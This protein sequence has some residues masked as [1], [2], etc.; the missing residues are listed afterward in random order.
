MCG[1]V[2][3]RVL[4][5][6][7]VVLSGSAAQAGAQVPDEQ[8]GWRGT[9]S[10]DASHESTTPVGSASGSASAVYY[11]DG[12]FA[13]GKTAPPIHPTRREW[14]QS[15]DWRGAYS[16][17]LDG[18][19]GGG[20][21]DRTVTF[22][23]IGSQ[24]A[25]DFAQIVIG[26]ENGLE[27]PPP[28][29]LA[30]VSLGPT[31]MQST[32]TTT[33][34][35]C[36]SPP[37]V[38]TITEPTA[39]CAPLI[40]DVANPVIAPEGTATITLTPT[41][42]DPTGGCSGG[43][44]GGWEAEV[45]WSLSRAPDPPECSDGKDNDI[46]KDGLIDYSGGLVQ[47]QDP[48]CENAQDNSEADTLTVCSDG[49]DNDNDGLIDLDDPGC[50]NA[51]D[52]EE[53]DS[54]CSDGH[55]NDGDDRNNYPDDPGCDSAED[56]T[57]APDPECGDLSDNDDDGQI[58]FPDDPD[59]V[60]ERDESEHC[61]V[62]QS[63]SS[64]DDEDEV[65]DR[66][67][68][69]EC[70]EYDGS[71]IDTCTLQPGDI[72]VDRGSN[73][74]HTTLFNTVLGGTYWTH[75]AIV[76]GYMNL[77]YDDEFP[78]DSDCTDVEPRFPGD[79]DPQCE[80]VIAEAVP[81]EADG[82]IRIKSIAN[83]VWGDK[84]D[85][86]TD[87]N[88]VRLTGVSASGR[89][90]AA[91]ALR[92]HLLYYGR[93]I[94]PGNHGDCTACDTLVWNASHLTY[95]VF[96]EARGPDHFYCS[97]LVWWAYEQVGIDLDDVPFIGWSWD[98]K[99]EALWVTPDELVSE[100]ATGPVYLKHPEPSGLITAI[101]SPA[102]LMLTDA[103]GRRTG[104]GADGVLLEQIPNAIWRDNGE[105]ESI[106]V[107]SAD[108]G[109]TLTIS[110]YGTGKYTL[111]T[112]PAD[113]SA[114]PQLAAGFTRP[115]QIETVALSALPTL[116]TRPVAADDTAAIGPDGA[117]VDVLAN[118]HNIADAELSIA[119]G[120][121]QG[122]AT[123]ADRKIRYLQTA[124]H[125]G[126][127]GLTYRV[128]RGGSCSDGV[129]T[130]QGRGGTEPGPEPPAARRAARV[131]VLRNPSAKHGVRLRIRCPDQACAVRATGRVTI[132]RKRPGLR[133]K[134]ARRVLPAGARATLKLMLPR[135]LQRSAVSAVRRRRAVVARMS[136]VIRHADGTVQ[137]VTRSARVRR[138]GG[139]PGPG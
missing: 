116:A 51:Q 120:A 103:L 69:L 98:D 4:L 109:W 19:D 115:G 60:D 84:Q 44:G 6:L 131:K 128:C 101:F 82:E 76:L 58:D 74:N 123:V 32:K 37:S 54:Q 10:V 83:T 64:D 27:P 130:L 111:L 24:N 14:I 136:I 129:V 112:R 3:A 104:K 45:S 23:A 15:L 90:E 121:S 86:N 126:D 70:K 29:A 100:E 20:D 55:D 133:L 11:L 77:D 42:N 56:L 92:N 93:A 95:Q 106:T 34:S 113:G 81:N 35:R 17:R 61:G 16:E 21:C 89:A 73:T 50:E 94:E 108:P 13:T 125:R 71:G 5:T 66:C 49:G 132:G 18:L 107:P 22:N 114:P 25:N 99:V 122:T 62:V 1:R 102:H 138:V 26:D 135:R 88:V 30:S 39:P 63:A 75:S 59:C 28:P 139:A 97:S 105:S 43:L 72:L 85:D 38:T 47:Y 36:V 79:R 65:D 134:P 124:G 78:T 137:R 40:G 117:I 119:S 12:E 53:A 46:P 68:D 91:A 33:L 48:G 8:L 41:S 9:I 118:D 80:L 67:D 96:T 52:E 87:W 31:P 2:L 57:E 7:A 110:G 127:D